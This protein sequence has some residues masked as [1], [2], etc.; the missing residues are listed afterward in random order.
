MAL[1]LREIG[2]ALW[3]DE[4]GAIVSAELAMVA[5]LGVVGATVGVD[6][7]SKSVNEELSDFAFAIRSFDQSYS[8]KRRESAGAHVAG[9]QFEQ[10]DVKTA[11][12]QLRKHKAD[13]EARQ[14]KQLESLKNDRSA[15]DQSEQTLAL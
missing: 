3:G 7:L 2:R 4:T 9:S 14:Q 6:T 12:E 5:T 10:L 11:H 13:V 1:R 8:V 15:I